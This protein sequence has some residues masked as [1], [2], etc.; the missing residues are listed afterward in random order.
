MLTMT[1]LKL[2][3]ISNGYPDIIS[4]PPLIKPEWRNT[5][6]KVMLSEINFEPNL[7]LIRNKSIFKQTSWDIIEKYKGKS[8]IT[9]S[10]ALKAFG[11]LERET[12]D[13]DLIAIDESIIKYKG[14]PGY[15]YGRQ[16]TPTFNIIGYDNV[17]LKTL[18]IFTN[19]TLRIDFFENK[20]QT[21]IEKDG[22][23]FHSP[24]E[25]MEQKIELCSDPYLR[26]DR[27]K[28]FEDFIVFNNLIEKKL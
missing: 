18:K 7:N 26:E 27:L 12:S 16:R 28:D 19:K 21:I 11:L 3:F 6:L 4:N 23:L 22:F 10:T 2:L 9:G 13:L 25:I 20:K 14:E 1:S 24:L 17:K 15:N 8:I 5:K